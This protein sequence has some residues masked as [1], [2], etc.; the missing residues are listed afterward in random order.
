MGLPVGVRVGVPVGVSVG[1]DGGRVGADEEGLEEG[2]C[3]GRNVGGG[4]PGAVVGAFVVRWCDAVGAGVAEPVSKTGDGVLV[5]DV[6][7]TTT[8]AAQSPVVT[9]IPA[10]PQ[11]DA[12]R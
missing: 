2:R 8:G 5:V 1:T 7:G 9:L 6:A 12:G 11:S 3:V 10:P 4:G